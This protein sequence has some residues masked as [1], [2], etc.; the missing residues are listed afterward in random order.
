M[1]KLQFLVLIIHI[2]Q[3]SS[4]TVDGISD[5]SCISK[6][7][8]DKYQVLYNSVSY[9]GTDLQS[10]MD[11]LNHKISQEA[12]ESAYHITTSHVKVAFDRLKPHKSDGCTDLTSDHL[13]HAG[14]DLFEHIAL[15]L[16]SVL[17][18]GTLLENFVYS[19]IVPMP[20]GR[21]VNAADS[22]NFRG[23]ALSSVYGK[24][25]YNIVLF[26]FRDELQTSQL[27]FG[28]KAKSIT[29]LCTFVLK[30]A[31]SYYATNQINVFCTFW[32][33]LRPLT[34]LIIA[35]FFGYC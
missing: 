22:N 3:L 2:A 7:F 5:A 12:T 20:K 32:M 10:I 14:T 23:I 6:L 1:Y 24:L 8:A 29:N 9:D 27:Q 33:P 13:K 11:E 21:N 17:I 15:L 18:H 26:Q 28:F 31:L 4:S 34:G 30:E 35:N 16:N 25:L 19:T